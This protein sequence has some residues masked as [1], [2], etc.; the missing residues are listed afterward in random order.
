M[1]NPMT[2]TPL[3]DHEA[4]ELAAGNEERK[5]YLLETILEALFDGMDFRLKETLYNS[6]GT[7]ASSKENTIDGKYAKIIVGQIV[8]E[9]S[10]LEARIEAQ[11]TAIRD[12]QAA[13]RE[14]SGDHR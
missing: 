14:R 6:D 12:L 13:A 11:E 3:S 8:R 5:L 2:H 4:R 1:S 10:N 7:V 9:F